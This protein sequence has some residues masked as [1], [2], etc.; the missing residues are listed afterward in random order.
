[1]AGF[2]KGVGG[3]LNITPSAVNVIS[4]TTIT[5][6]RLAEEMD[7][8]RPHLQSVT[9]SVSVYYT[10]SAPGKSSRDIAS[11]ITAQASTISTSLV[12]SGF[13]GALAQDAYESTFAPSLT[14]TPTPQ[15]QRRPP[16]DRP[17]ILPQEFFV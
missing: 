17:F 6:R 4:I 10:L 14:P 7:R 9:S 3:L 13:D 8:H 2:Q 11:A 1:M 12:S 16:Q 5:A 15:A